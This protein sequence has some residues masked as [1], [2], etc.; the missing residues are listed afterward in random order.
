MSGF[1][2]A[3]NLLIELNTLLTYLIM[4]KFGLRFIL[5]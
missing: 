2:V 1:F 3:P 5:L 4:P